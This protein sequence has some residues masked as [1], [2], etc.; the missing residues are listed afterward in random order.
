[1]FALIH[2][3]LAI[4]LGDLLCRRFYRFVSV[5]HR[6]A[7]AILVGILLSTW[8][9]YLA[10]LAFAH[11]AEPLLWADLLFFVAA[12]AAIFWLSRKSPKVQMIETR[13]P[14][15]A[16]YDWI[17]LGALF[18]AVCVL[19]MGTLYVNKQGRI[20]VSG[21][22][23][24]DFA[25][26]SA[27]AQSFAL[28]HNF[29]PES[30]YYAGQS[31]HHDFL[32]YF[33]AG[34]LESL[35]LN[36]A[37]SVD[38]LSVLGLTSMLAL[39]MTLGE[40]LFNS[41]VVGRIGATLFF[42]PGSL[43]FVPLL[44]SQSSGTPVVSLNQRHLPGAMAVF[45]L[46]LIFLADRYRQ[47]L[48]QPQA[49]SHKANA[50]A[51]EAQQKAGLFRHQSWMAR[52]ALVPASSFI[53]SGVLLGALPLWSRSVFTAAAAV[54]LFLVILIPY[55]LP[56]LLL[57]VLGMV[58][59]L[60]QLF[61][62]R[63]GGIAPEQPLF[64]GG[65]ILN[66]P[67]VPKVIA[68][69][70][71]MVGAK[72]PVIIVA[73][74]LASWVQWRFFLAL[75]SLFLLTVY[76]GL[77][78]QT[79]EGYNFVNIWMIVANLFAGCGLWHLWKLKKPPILGPA[80]AIVLTATIVA[81]GAIELFPIR[82]SSYVEVNYEKDDL[83]TWL[84]KNTKPNDV[85]L[86]DRFFTHPILLAGR[87]IFLG[88][89]NSPAAYDLAKRESIYRQMFESKN[90]RRVH[91][92]LKDDHIEYVAFDDGVRHGELIKE[93]NEQVYTTYFQKV[94]QDK[95]KRYRGLVIYRV[96]DSLPA[97][98]PNEDLSEP[99]VTAFQGGVGT[100]KGRFNTPRAIAVD[101]TGNIFVA[102]TGNERIEKFSPT[103]TFLSIIGA[104]GSGHAQLADPNGI[105]I[106]RSGNIYVAE[107]DSK[108][109]VQK[110]GPDGTLVAAWAPELFGPRRIAIGPDDS[111]Y[112]VD[113]GRNRIVKTSPDGQVL[114]TWGSE[115][116]GDGQFSGVSS[117]AVDPRINQVYVA[118]PLNKRIQV[119]D[120]TGRFLTKWPVPEW[121]QQLGFEDL[122]V[123]PDRD[124][125]YASSGH[126]NIILVFDLQGNRI[127][128][129]AP[130][131]P[132]K[133][134]GPSGLALAKDKLFV[135][136]AASARVS[137][138]PLPAR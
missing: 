62:L 92:L 84:R 44:K 107:I 132:D 74:I 32:F 3:G 88:S 2:L 103:G 63:L 85:F 94:Y 110:L 29:P 51:D 46:V 90:P 127:A 16:V 119:F 26:Q 11:A 78:I 30:P 38:V 39:L 1:M 49:K 133:L 70:G 12:A 33:Q 21:M 40:L 128:T 134:E 18:I 43:A 61:F 77:S 138:I 115:G 71:Y 80:T 104:K 31:Y 4:T 111:I 100:G 96:P 45:L 109:R 25:L 83:V 135:L 64:H 69:I 56:V 6:Y 41:R 14:G 82:N 57:G 125:L 27:I 76:T 117:V 93:P 50:E 54:L 73:L 13:A 58:V 68:Y 36:L 102:D 136:N 17:T 34:N 118:D 23:A 116:S 10:G 91:K 65:G 66:N 123:D 59:A 112:V 19:L 42:F 79:S 121:G 137:V 105:A 95:E 87:K 108:H 53:F 126:M 28:G 130:M 8:F 106:D 86:T 75:C 131:P 122:A 55:R 113:S 15:R 101:T 98:V 72:W 124:R 52:N 129:L 97:T 7:G 89:N 9:T 47:R 5:P 67:T 99:P 24:S 37:W 114:T 60:P 20:R 120:A 81:G 35:G 48:P 22:E